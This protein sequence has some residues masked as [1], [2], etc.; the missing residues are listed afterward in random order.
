[1]RKMKEKKYSVANNLKRYANR[2]QA[3]NQLIIQ[4]NLLFFS[5][6]LCYIL[7]HTLEEDFF[8]N[9]KAATENIF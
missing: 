1:M 8:Y 2:L 7:L 3:E 5:S 6:L 9:K 4:F